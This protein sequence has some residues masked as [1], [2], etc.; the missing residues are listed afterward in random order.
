MKY[1]IR[2]NFVAEINKICYL[3]HI[4][5]NNLKYVIHNN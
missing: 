1:V 3:K 4:A 5:H 2:D